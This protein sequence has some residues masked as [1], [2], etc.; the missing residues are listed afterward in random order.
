MTYAHAQQTGF[1]LTVLAI[2]E[3]AVVVAMV[4]AGAPTSALI[5]VFAVFA[6]VVV[7]A[8]IFSRLTIE[9]DDSEVRATFGRGWPRKAVPLADANLVRRV[10]NRWWYG[11]GIRKVPRGWMW[12]VWGLDAVELELSNGKVLRLG[13]DEP[14][15]L[16]AALAGIVPSG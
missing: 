7:I 12:N 9:V 4:V 1:G 11:F 2:L 3:A 6:L 16:L 8:A 14:D 5:G 15:T 13:T 10:R